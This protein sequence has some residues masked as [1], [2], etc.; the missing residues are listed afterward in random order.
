MLNKH[1]DLVLANF[2]HS[3]TF[4]HNDDTLRFESFG[5]SK[6]HPPEMLYPQKK[7]YGRQVDIWNIGILLYFLIQ[8]R[9]PFT[10]NK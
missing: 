4:D 5:A 10:D 6:F 2:G 1:F 7:V 9:F 8:D 3:K